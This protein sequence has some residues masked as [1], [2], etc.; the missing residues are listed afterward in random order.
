[1]TYFCDVVWPGVATLRHPDRL[2]PYTELHCELQPTELITLLA[3]NLLLLGGCAVFGFLTRKLP[4]NFNESHFMFVSVAT[5]IFLWMVM[6]PT[7]FTTFY[8]IYQSALLAIC[9]LLNAY[10]TLVCLFIP[11]LYAVYFVSEENLEFGAVTGV[12]T[13]SNARPSVSNMGN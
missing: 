2:E 4:A 13:I 8:A 1:M 3:C 9:L 10:I 7:Y 5:T 6:L 12:G 11:K